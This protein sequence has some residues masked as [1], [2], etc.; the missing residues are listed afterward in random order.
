[1]TR[2][3][4][5]SPRARDPRVLAPRPLVFRDQIVVRMR[6][7]L[8]WMDRIRL[9][10]ARGLTVIVRTDTENHLGRTQ[11]GGCEVLVP[12]VF[13]SRAPK[14]PPP[15]MATDAGSWVG[16]DPAATHPDRLHS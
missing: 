16:D 14:L 9:F 12:H 8:T 15:E 3:R 13:P 5:R 6:I 10:F 1:M 2:P 11:D 7:Q 4:T